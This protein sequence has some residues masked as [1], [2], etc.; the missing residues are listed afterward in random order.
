MNGIIV[1]DK[2]KGY[3]SFDVI[4]VLRKKLHQKKIGH[5]GTLD[6]MATGVLPILLGE[7][8]KFQIFATNNDKAYIAEM[9]LGVTTDTLDVTGKILSKIESHVTK[10]EL[11]KILS[12]FKGEIN[13]VPP[14]FSAIKKNGKKLCDLARRGVNVEREARIITIKSLEI[15]NFNEENQ[16]IKINVLCSKG[17][18]IRSLCADIGDELHCGSTMTYLRRTLSN[19]FSEKMSLSLEK[20][21]SSSMEEIEKNYILPTEHLFKNEKSVD[22]TAAQAFRFKNG[23]NLMISRLDIKTPYCNDQIFKVYV[24]NQFIGIGKV[25]TESEELKFLKCQSFNME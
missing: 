25:C 11:E 4:A 10:K 6:P 5:M 9:Q 14:M 23:G 16:T 12:N 17:T 8:A 13:Q 15:M 2:P 21:I 18:Y 19:G 3:T 1:I 24:N 7:T 20:I 22:I